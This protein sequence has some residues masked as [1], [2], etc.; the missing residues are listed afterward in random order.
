LAP[1]IYTLIT[2]G[3]IYYR[4]GNFN[5]IRL[6]VN[7]ESL[8]YS[9]HFAAAIIKNAFR[10]STKSLGTIDNIYERLVDHLFISLM[11]GM[12]CGLKGPKSLQ[13][14]KKYLL[15]ELNFGNA[16]WSFHTKKEWANW[17]YYLH[18][19]IR[20]STA[21]MAGLSSFVQPIFILSD[22]QALTLGI[23]SSEWSNGKHDRVRSLNRA[24]L[25][26]LTVPYSDGTPYT[27]T[28]S[29][30]NSLAKINQEY[31]YTLNSYLKDP[32]KLIS[33]YHN[34]KRMPAPQRKNVFSFDEVNFRAVDFT[35]YFEKEFKSM[36]LDPTY[37]YWL[38]RAAVTI[39]YTLQFL[40][41]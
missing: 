7:R 9:G 38:K 18:R 29:L 19:G 14:L 20:W 22:L 23:S 1:E 25:P 27:V 35:E 37:S 17:F 41:H 5:C 13:D 39:G 36:V 40:G 10:G 34:R 2:D 6:G 28:E 30:K 8:F 15:D 12:I 4:G 31:F 3:Q 11:D 24:L 21:T 32:K 33:Y 26:E 16:Y